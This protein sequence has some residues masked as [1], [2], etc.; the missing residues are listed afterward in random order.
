M[1]CSWCSCRKAREFGKIW[2]D[3]IASGPVP[4][5]GV[6]HAAGVGGFQA[7]RSLQ[8]TDF[9]A[10]LQPKVIGGWLLHSLTVAHALDFFVAT[11]L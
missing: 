5:R 4:L 10:M 3:Q 7:L 8:W 2:Q 9:V 1:R 6:I 11:K